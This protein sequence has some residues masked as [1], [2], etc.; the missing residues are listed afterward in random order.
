[1]KI[2]YNRLWKL[3]I[4]KGMRKNDLQKI[5]NISP[6]TITKMGHNETVTTETLIKICVALECT[7]DDIVEVTTTG[8]EV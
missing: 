8:K 4:D 1:M 2:S 3:L 5:A 7:M 6:S